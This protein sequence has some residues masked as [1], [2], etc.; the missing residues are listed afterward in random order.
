MTSSPTVQQAV[1][2][3]N[4]IILYNAST[5]DGLRNFGR[6]FSNTDST[7]YTDADMDASLNVYYDLFV[8][9]ILESMDGWDFQGEVATAALVTDQQEYS[10]PTDIMKIKRVEVTYDGTNWYN[11]AFMDINERGAATDTTSISNDFS[12]SKPYADLHDNSL[13]LYPIPGSGSAAGLKI[14]YEKL[15]TALSAA[16][17]EPVIAR[18]F[19]TG[20]AYGAAKDYLETNGDIPGN[21]IRLVQAQKNLGIIISNMKQF[22][23]KRNQ[24][25]DIVALPI[26]E[27]YG[28]GHD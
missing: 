17:D 13:F 2:K 4:Q 18:Q 24:D 25:R 22:Y 3:H 15:P 26:F 20:L 7:T 14:W 12:E 16:T 9:E 21:D 11:V 28:Y 27:D 1:K 5:S 19:Q 6:R 10:F 23:N 8:N